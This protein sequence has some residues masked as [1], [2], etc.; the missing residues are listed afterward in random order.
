MTLISLRARSLNFFDR[1]CL[2]GFPWFWP[3]R[4]PGVPAM[5]AARRIARRQF[6]RDHRHGYR[7]LGQ[8]VTAITWPF[9]VMVQLWQVRR[10]R[11][12]RGAPISRIPGALWAAFRHN[13][14]PGEY[15]AYALWQSPRKANIDNY[16]YCREGTRLFKVLNRPTHPN[17]LDD[18]LAFHKLCKRL[19]LPSPDILAA[20][21][22]SGEL[23]LEFELGQPPKRDLFVKPRNGVGGEG[24]EYFRWLS[25][26]FESEH[27][28]QLTPEALGSYL[29]E[30]ALTENRA[31]LV[32]PALRNSTQLQLSE[33]S[34]L[35]TA[36]LVTGLTKHADVVPIFGVFFYIDRTEKLHARHALIDVANAELSWESDD[37]V[38]KAGSNEVRT[39]PDWKLAL[40]Y[41]RIAHQECPNFIFVGWDVAFTE[42]G[43]VL[44]EGNVNWA[45]DDFQRLRGEPLGNTRFADILASRLGL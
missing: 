33:K 14:Q 24:S 35:A 13:V 18:K 21:A 37:K 2:V 12:S 3:A 10:F 42:Q 23:L 26:C 38:F 15:F 11:G 25:D 9:A 43:P 27:G 31:L 5:V 8:I 28:C 34:S 30:R 32:Q 19:A 45:A 39:L 22:P 16:L 36:R 40:R 6:G 44:L 20:F 29:A 4:P 1:R 41:A 7:I 17:P